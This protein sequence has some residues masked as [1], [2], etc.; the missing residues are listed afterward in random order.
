MLIFSLEDVETRRVILVNIWIL[1][2][3]FIVTKIEGESL[4]LPIL[5]EF[6]VKS[7]GTF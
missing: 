7:P 3:T 5:S 4:A 6:E 1:L 2:V